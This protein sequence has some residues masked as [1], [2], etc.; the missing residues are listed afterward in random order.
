[1]SDVAQAEVQVEEPAEITKWRK[2][3]ICGCGECR[4]KPISFEC[5][6]KTAPTA[7]WLWVSDPKMIGR[8]DY[9][10]TYVGRDVPDLG[11]EPEP[12]V[13]SGELES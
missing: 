8:L 2:S 4:F 5:P 10:D 11:E 1:M 13:Q 6:L 7:I 9:I 12:V 3:R